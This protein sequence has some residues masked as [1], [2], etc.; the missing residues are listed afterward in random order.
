MDTFAREIPLYLRTANTTPPPTPRRPVFE[1][2][3][4]MRRIFFLLC[5]LCVTAASAAAQDAAK[6]D[7]NHYTV[8]FE[9]EQVRVLRIRYGPR[10]KSVMHRHPAGVAIM[11]T[12]N[13][14]KFTFADG[15]T[16]ERQM[17]AGQVIEAEAVTHLP[18]NPSDQ[19]FEAI[20]VEVKAAPA[21]SGRPKKQ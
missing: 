5:F 2:K 14:M 15:R 11:L 16:E 20:L 13:T 7:S 21:K 9:N 4:C 8:E 19:P 17:K 18:E 1:R 6:V 12:D 10:E 3:T